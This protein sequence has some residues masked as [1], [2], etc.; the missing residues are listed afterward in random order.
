MS[1]PKIFKLVERPSIPNQLKKK[2]RPLSLSDYVFTIQNSLASAEVEAIAKRC[3]AELGLDLLAQINE[4]YND[5]T[6]WSV[7]WSVDET[8]SWREMWAEHGQRQITE[9][10]K[11]LSEDC[12]FIVDQESKGSKSR[13]KRVD[14]LLHGNDDHPTLS[15]LLSIKWQIKSLQSSALAFYAEPCPKMEDPAPEELQ[16][17]PEEP[18]AHPEES[19]GRERHSSSEETPIRETTNAE[20]EL[21]E[22]Y[23]ALDKFC[24]NRRILGATFL[25]LSSILPEYGS[26]SELSGVSY[27]KIQST[28]WTINK[29]SPIPALQT[30]I[31]S[32]RLHTESDRERAASGSEARMFNTEILDRQAHIT[33]YSK[34]LTDLIKHSQ[35]NVYDKELTYTGVAL[36]VAL[37]LAR[38][39]ESLLKT[40]WFSTLCSCHLRRTKS[41]D[42]S[43]GT[44]LGAYQ[45]HQPSTR[46]SSHHWCHCVPQSDLPLRRLG[47]VLME[48]ILG[49][50]RD[51]TDADAIKAVMNGD[52]PLRDGYLRE[53]RE[54]AEGYADLSCYWDAVSF[55]LNDRTR[56]KDINGRTL[57]KYYQNVVLP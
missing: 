33:N 36:E 15:R 6:Y 3:D 13:S 18:Q 49:T 19:Q 8:E 37:E 52:R 11:T 54:C 20:L 17:N 41:I 28:I 35:R 5:I 1:F 9:K 43:I 50:T 27:P 57:D 14:T 34:S 24:T 42:G 45:P 4:W 21:Q 26:A 32:T 55:C 29:N 39:G 23:T 22:H 56:T 44:A 47:V 48:T 38:A 53:L 7:C 30:K 12:R 40:P 16:T 10:L 25:E 31:T 51:S 46:T 2:R